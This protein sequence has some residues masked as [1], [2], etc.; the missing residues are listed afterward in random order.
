MAEEQ[1]FDESGELE[2]GHPESDAELTGESDEQAPGPADNSAAS[3]EERPAQDEGE[4]QSEEKPETRAPE[5]YADFAL[6]EGITMDEAQIAE[7]RSFAKEHDLTQ[8]QAQKVLEFGAA[9]VRERA[10]APYKL[11][12]ET[13]RKWQ[14]E[15][16]ADPEIG[17]AKFEQS[18]KDA[19]LVFVPGEGNPFVGSAEEA[20]TL[21]EALDATGAGN[22]PAVVK[23]FVK[24]GRLLA[25]PAPFSGKPSAVDKQGDLLAKMYPTMGE[26][27]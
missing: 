11:W 10:E 26:T 22:N 16:K 15:V 21:R 24:M 18:I 1:A 27:K 12:S 19:G 4:A 23:L 17:G 25:E 2:K 5:E 6:P 8:E 14:A 13:Q 7:F 9:K 3:E 20:K